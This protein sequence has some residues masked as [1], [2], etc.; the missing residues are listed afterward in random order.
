MGSAVRCLVCQQYLFVESTRC[1]YSTG[2]PNP[3]NAARTITTTTLVLGILIAAYYGH[4]KY[5]DK[6]QKQ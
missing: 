4:L 2:G 1:F 3:D 6:R 5:D